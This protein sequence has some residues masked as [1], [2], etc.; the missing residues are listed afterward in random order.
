M[1]PEVRGGFAEMQK[2]C[3]MQGDH[4]PRAGLENISPRVSS[5]HV[6]YV[7]AFSGGQ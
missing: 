1:K 5:R 4:R 7:F 3:R 2:N 6:V